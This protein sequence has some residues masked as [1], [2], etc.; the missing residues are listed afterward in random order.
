MNKFTYHNVGQGLMYSFNVENY[1]YMYDCYTLDNIDYL[2]SN[3]N[4]FQN[5]N[6]EFLVISSINIK[7]FNGLNYLLDNIDSLHTLYLPYLPIKNRDNILL[8][9]LCNGFD[10]N[11]EITSFLIDVYN[12][13]DDHLHISYK[14]KEFNVF[15]VN[16]IMNI[17]TNI[18][19]FYLINNLKLEIHQYN[20]FYNKIISIINENTI[21]ELVSNDN[22]TIVKLRK[23][24]SEFFKG[25]KTNIS[26]VS[27]IHYTDKKFI[28]VITGDTCKNNDLLL[29]LKQYKN[30]IKHLLLPNHGS[31]VNSKYFLKK[32]YKVENYYISFGIGNKFRHPS[33][34]TIE[35]LKVNNKN[36]YLV[37]QLS[38]FENEF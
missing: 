16:S 21:E 28:N 22:S 3:I 35:F 4:K 5:S 15:L 24:Y 13:E 2:N 19:N 14:G 8:Y 11:D 37:N 27:L 30:K 18:H 36:I 12:N 7:Y 25:H 17:S 6:L 20:M 32:K 23:R 33:T 9:L 34:K 26:S 10:I 31:Y 38:D 1:N 29:F